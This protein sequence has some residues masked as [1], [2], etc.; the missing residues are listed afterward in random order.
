MSDWGPPAFHR[1]R[2]V[3]IAAIAV[4]LLLAAIGGLFATAGAFDRDPLHVF[5]ADGARGR[6]GAVYFSGDMGLRFGMGGPTSR[7]LARHGVNVVA[8]SSSTL[9]ASRRTRA[10]VDRIVA[11]AVRQGLR[12][13]GADRLVLIGQ[14]FGA[15]IL[16]TGLAALPVELREKVAGVVLV[17]PGETVFFRADPSSIV[18]HGKPDSIALSTAPALTWTPLTCIYGTSETDSLCP[19]LPAMA[20]LHKVA[21][22]GGHFLNRDGAA[23]IAQV[24]AAVRRAAPDSVHA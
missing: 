2:G 9:F 17:V 14:S 22:P 3:R 5:A 12:R 20:D 24:L 10:E 16:Q 11:D 23:L 6:V 4:A 13:T 1:R 15:D 18:Y 7:A 19:R 8:F 21:M